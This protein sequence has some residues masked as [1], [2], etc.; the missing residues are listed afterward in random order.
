M[1]KAGDELV[2]L[3]NLIELERLAAVRDLK[4]KIFRC[5]LWFAV[6]KE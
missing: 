5:K 6:N 3:A 4:A 2:R 1:F